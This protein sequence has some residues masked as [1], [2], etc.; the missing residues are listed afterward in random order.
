MRTAKPAVVESLSVL[1]VDEDPEILSFFARVLDGS[2]MR[3]LLARGPHE[4]IGIARRGYVPI[5][6]VLTDVSLKPDAAEPDLS[7]GSQ[8]V[9]RLRELRPEVRAL[10]MSAYL[11]S[12]VIRIELMNSGLETASTGP[13]GKGLVEWIRNAGA[14]PMVHRMGG[15]SRY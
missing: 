9:E 10:F 5:D 3:A 4:A 14:A 12:G 1:V 6:M 13:D 15:T 8:L 11:E 2:G 7:S